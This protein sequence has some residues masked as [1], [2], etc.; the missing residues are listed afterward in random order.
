MI[1][2]IILLALTCLL[3]AWLGYKLQNNPLLW[4]IMGLGIMLSIP[5]VCTPFI[6][7]FF[8][9]PTA[10]ILWVTVFIVSFLISLAIAAI[11]ACRDGLFAKSNAQIT[12]LNS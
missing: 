5:L 12:N 11:I 6:L 8:D 4:G 9:P 2:Q 3:Y 7:L 1:L 10:L